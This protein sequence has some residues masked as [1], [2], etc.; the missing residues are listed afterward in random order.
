MESKT[1]L[2][3]KDAVKMLEKGLELPEQEIDFRNEKIEFKYASLFNRSEIIVPEELVVY[4][5][6]EI[7]F[8][9]DADVT[10]TESQ[11]WLKIDELTLEQEVMDWMETNHIDPQALA[12]RLI[13]DFYFTLKEVRNSTDL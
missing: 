12:N 5:D 13:R 10:E 3:W 8:S 6:D 2:Y 1:K 11:H 9:D 4:N 7:D